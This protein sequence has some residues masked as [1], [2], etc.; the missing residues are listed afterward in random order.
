MASS[1]LFTL[2]RKGLLRGVG[3]RIDRVMAYYLAA[4]RSQSEL[5]VGVRSLQ[6]TI[7][8]FNSDPDRLRSQVEQDLIA[9]FTPLFDD[10][11]ATVTIQDTST[12]DQS[13]RMTIVMDVVVWKGTQPY[14]VG[15]ELETI[16]GVVQS[17][18]TLNNTG[19]TST[20]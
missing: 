10:V 11:A 4:N 3:E 9:L 1:P 14:S 2:S 18:I 8:L 17:M 19:Q 6:G 7:Q 12:F 15:K 20:S 16:N 13:N 5:Y